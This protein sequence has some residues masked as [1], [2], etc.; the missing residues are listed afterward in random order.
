M[1]YYWKK[2]NKLHI[3][4][5]K[6]KTHIILMSRSSAIFVINVASELMHGSQ[7]SLHH[8]KA[9]RILFL[10]VPRTR[11]LGVVQRHRLANEKFKAPPS[12]Y[13]SSEHGVTFASRLM[14]IFKTVSQFRTWKNVKTQ[15]KMYLKR[16]FVWFQVI[17]AVLSNIFDNFHWP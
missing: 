11:Y 7:S 9:E 10:L 14:P 16:K 12:D 17:P 5:F 1:C 8:C 15:A 3:F 6:W 13:R 4:T 2:S